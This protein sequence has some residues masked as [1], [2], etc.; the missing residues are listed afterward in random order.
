MSQEQEFHVN[1]KSVIIG[2]SILIY[3]TLSIVVVFVED[4]GIDDDVG[5]LN[6]S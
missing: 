5:N 4:N 2:K 6:V 1:E 3:L